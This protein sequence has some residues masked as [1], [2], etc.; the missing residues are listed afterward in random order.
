MANN[1]LKLEK[2]ILQIQ[3]RNKKVEID[4]AWETS[5]ERK[6][7]VA[8]TTYFTMVLLMFVIKTNNPFIDAIIPA[9]GF[10]LSTLSLEIFKSKWI[11]FKRL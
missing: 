9:C 8:V 3:K 5:T 10:L 4:K 7:I 1:I 11:K 6:I 2:E